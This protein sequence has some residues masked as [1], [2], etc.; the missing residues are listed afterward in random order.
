MPS[1]FRSTCTTLAL[2]ASYLGSS[3]AQAPSPSEQLFAPLGALQLENHAIIE[4]CA[5]GYRTIGTLNAKRSNAVLIP[6]WFNGKTAD[7]QNVITPKGLL[8][9]K[10]YYVIL[11]DAIGNGVSCSPS[12]SSK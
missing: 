10:S 12:N 7:I 4:D 5:L 6:T 11:V 3:W 9:P 1:I 2:C 8:D